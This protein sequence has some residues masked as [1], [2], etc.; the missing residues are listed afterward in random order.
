MRTSGRPTKAFY[1]GGVAL[2]VAA[3]IGM[4]WTMWHVRAPSPPASAP[5][6]LAPVAPSDSPQVLPGL[7][8]RVESKGTA[9]AS[10]PTAVG[11]PSAPASLGA[12]AVHPAAV[13][14]KAIRAANPV[15]TRRSGTLHITTEHATPPP[16]IFEVGPVPPKASARV[17]CV[18]C[19]GN[20][21]DVNF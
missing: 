5:A 17:A 3:L 4:G 14:P 9:P 7:R 16:Q 11:H 21:L 10:R 2:I 15:E 19:P 13:L 1:L 12:A 18:T 20:V 6:G 8:P